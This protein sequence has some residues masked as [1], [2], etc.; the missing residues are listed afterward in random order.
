MRLEVPGVYIGYSLYWLKA[1]NQNDFRY[2]GEQVLGPVE[3]AP[4]RPEKTNALVR[5]WRAIWMR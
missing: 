4:E 1:A 5:M 3:E 2:R